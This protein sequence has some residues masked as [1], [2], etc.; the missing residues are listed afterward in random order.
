MEYS[1]AP[2]KHDIP[3]LTIPQFILDSPHPLSPS[4]PDSIPFF[5][6]DS[7]GRKLHRSEVSRPRL[8]FYTL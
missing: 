8:L 2:L 7:T 1:G 6:E 5:I 3:N 4:R